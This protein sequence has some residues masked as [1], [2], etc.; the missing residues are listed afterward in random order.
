MTASSRIA[1]FCDVSEDAVITAKDVETIYE[2]PLVLAAEGLDRIILKFLHLP[3]TEARTA[4]W[5]ELGHRIKN[6]KD[7]L[8]IH[9]VGKYTGY[10]GSYK[11]PKRAGYHGWL[12]NHL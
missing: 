9:V 1:L 12:G 3:E 11:S 2:V 6:P 8:T 7:E 4:A 5:Q 10:E